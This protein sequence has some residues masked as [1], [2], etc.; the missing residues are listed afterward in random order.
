MHL[1]FGKQ[2][3]YVADKHLYLA[4]LDTSANISRDLPPQTNAQYQLGIERF[5]IDKN[6]SPYGDGAN[7]LARGRKLIIACLCRRI[8][9]IQA[10]KYALVII[11]CSSMSPF[12]S[13]FPHI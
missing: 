8:N 12:K 6:L 1:F 9:G 7:V 2:A 5:I 13:L 11:S 4:S 3:S 10:E